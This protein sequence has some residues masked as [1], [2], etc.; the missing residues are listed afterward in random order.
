MFK[1]NFR[2]I[3]TP[4]SHLRLTLNLSRRRYKVYVNMSALRELEHVSLV[5]KMNRRGAGTSITQLNYMKHF[6]RFVLFKTFE[7]G[8]KRFL[9]H[10][11]VHV[12]GIDN[13]TMAAASVLHSMLNSIHLDTNFYFI[14]GEYVRT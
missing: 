7:R 6:Y 2:H 5:E 13:R 14:S 8:Q 3:L 9:R 4:G 1:W 11:R 10:L 12:S